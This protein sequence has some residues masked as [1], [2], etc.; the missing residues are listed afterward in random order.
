MEAF[1]CA[2]DEFHASRY[3]LHR[4]ELDEE[5]TQLHCIFNVSNSNSNSTLEN[6]VALPHL[7][8]LGRCNKPSAEYQRFVREGNRGEYSI[9]DEQSSGK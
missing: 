4:L 8:A 1:S 7:N 9:L 5:A 3:F 6:A 2:V